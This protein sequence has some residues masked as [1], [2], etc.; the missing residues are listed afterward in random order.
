MFNTIVREHERALLFRDGQLAGYLRPG[1]HRRWS[2]GRELKIRTYGTDAGFVALDPE[3]ERAV[4]HDEGEVLEVAEDQ[5]ALLARADQPIAV[6][7]PGRYLLWQVRGAVL[8]ELR[9]RGGVLLE[10][11]APFR[12]LVPDA[13]GLEVI[14]QAHERVVVFVDGELKVVLPPG[15]HLIDAWRRKVSIARVE[16]REQELGSVGQELI[17][18]DKVSL[19]LNLLLKHRIVDPVAAVSTVTDLRTALYGEMQIVAREVVG[20]VTVDELLERRVELSARMRELIGAR[21]ETWGVEAIRLDIKDVVLPG[22]MKLLLNRVI[23]A[24]KQAAAQVI[25]RREEVAATRSLANTAKML[26]SNPVLLRLKE[27]EALQELAGTIP[28]LTVVFG[29]EELTERLRLVQRRD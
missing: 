13:L 5:L 19:R 14:V 15:R 7:G 2:F 1:R 28:N 16:L 18:R 11:P 22:D 9:A 23:E 20:G 29:G 27:L 10:V 12:A 25:L 21:S 17:T 6:L 26:E 3:L 8:T 4:P 24:E